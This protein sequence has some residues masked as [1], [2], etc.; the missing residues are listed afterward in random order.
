MKEYLDDIKNLYKNVIHY[1]S[2]PEY[3][4]EAYQQECHYE[5]YVNDCLVYSQYE[6]VQQA[7]H[8]ITINPTILKSGPIEVKIKLMALGTIEDKEYTTLEENTGFEL[9]IFKRD[10]QVPW[11]GLEY[12][13]VAEY[14]APTT[15]GE[16][17]G[18]FKNTGI[19]IY[20]D[21]FTLDVEVP[22]HSTGWSESQLI[23]DQKGIETEVLTYY[24][25]IHRII[26]ERNHKEWQRKFLSKET[27]IAQMIYATKDDM[28]KRVASYSSSFETAYLDVL[29][30]ENYKVVF[31]GNGRIIGLESL[32]HKGE[33]ALIS[34]QEIEQG[35]EKMKAYIFHTLYL[36]KPKGSNT[37]EVIR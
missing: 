1:N 6:N 3:Y 12:D 9:I 31:Y 19:P 29:P 15:T 2:E 10:K 24:K 11:E 22:Y 33:S 8:A 17:G 25:D 23:V 36:H 28:K 26:K 14:I 13:L 20:E 35:E 30:I 21:T 32:E 7:N 5:I 16:K 4:V 18:S 37:L 27:E 34:I